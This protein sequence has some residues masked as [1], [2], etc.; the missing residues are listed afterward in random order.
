MKTLT[1]LALLLALSACATTTLDRAAVAQNLTNVTEVTG[2]NA[3]LL[4]ASAMPDS[5]KNAFRLRNEAAVRLAQSM[6]DSA[7]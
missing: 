1:T 6:K 5:A 7:Q 2:Q 3:T 4:E